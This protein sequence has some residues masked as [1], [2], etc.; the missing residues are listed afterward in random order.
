MPTGGVA[1]AVH[2]YWK[3]SISNIIKF[4][5]RHMQMT[6]QGEEIEKPII[7]SNTYAPHKGY[8]EEKKEKYWENIIKRMKNIKKK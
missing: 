5:E 8:S 1:I 2:E 6:I 7:I 3:E 4:D